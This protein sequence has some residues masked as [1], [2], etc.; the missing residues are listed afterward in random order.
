[1]PDPL[2]AHGTKLPPRCTAELRGVHESAA[3]CVLGE[4]HTGPHGNS[5][6]QYWADLA[7]DDDLRCRLEYAE[8]PEG[9][10]RCILEEDHGATPH[11]LG[12]AFAELHT[13]R[14]GLNWTDREAADSALRMLAVLRSAAQQSTQTT[15]PA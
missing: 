7:P 3:R 5:V 1:M 8:V 4:G 14:A 2:L 6:D 9:D 13:N 11:R 12:R 10:R 15:S